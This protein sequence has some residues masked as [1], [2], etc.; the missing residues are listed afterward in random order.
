MIDQFLAVTNSTPSFLLAFAC[1]GIFAVTAF[2]IQC[3]WLLV[4][5]PLFAWLGGL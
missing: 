3:V 4:L 2:A 5:R 1:L